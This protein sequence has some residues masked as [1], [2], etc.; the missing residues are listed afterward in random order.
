[1]ALLSI[2]YAALLPA[3]FPA[4][5]VR[6]PDL[7]AGILALWNPGILLSFEILWVVAFLHT[8]MSRVTGA[9]VRLHV[10][11]ERV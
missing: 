7:A 4:S 11:K 5:G 6:T 10:V 8:G 9:T 2:V 3:F 1:M